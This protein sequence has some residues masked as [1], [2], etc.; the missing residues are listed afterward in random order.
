MDLDLNY[1]FN[2]LATNLAYALVVFLGVALIIALLINDRDAR[3]WTVKGSAVFLIVSALIFT[4]SMGRLQFPAV[5]VFFGNVWQSGLSL[6]TA[7]ASQPTVNVQVDVP[8]ATVIVEEGGV[9]DTAT[10]PKSALTEAPAEEAPEEIIPEPE[11]EEER[12]IFDLGSVVSD[13]SFE[14]GVPYFLYEIQ[15]GDTV[16][17]LSRRFGITQSELRDRN[18]LRVGD[19]IRIGRDLKIPIGGE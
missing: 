11:L 3:V 10:E 18:G 1:L 9:P 15:R 6:T 12:S 17:D 13:G 14:D 2:A 19:T 5:D 7:Q 4:F 16:Y 8:P